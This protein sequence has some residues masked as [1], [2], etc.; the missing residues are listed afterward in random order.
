MIRLKHSLCDSCEML[1]NMVAFWMVSELGQKNW[2]PP[3][4]TYQA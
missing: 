1:S 2:D 3:R 4:S